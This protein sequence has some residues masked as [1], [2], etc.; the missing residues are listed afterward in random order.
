MLNISVTISKLV[1]HMRIS[2][3]NFTIVAKPQKFGKTD[4]RQV[5]AREAHPFPST[6]QLTHSVRQAEIADIR[7]ETPVQEL[8]LKR[9]QSLPKFIISNV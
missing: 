8:C 5:S 7:Q 1:R 9:I 2:L 4:D 3:F 6:H